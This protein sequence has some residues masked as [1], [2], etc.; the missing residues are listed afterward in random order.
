MACSSGCLT[1]DH[2]SYGDCLRSK[3]LQVADVEAHA[4]RTNQEHQIRE[5]QDA[6]REGMQPASFFKRDVDF[7]RA[8]TKA[9][10]GVPYRA[11]Q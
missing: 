5:Y 10:G 6:R 1:Q 4:Y 11:D 7:A 9:A 8:A 3:S 2:A